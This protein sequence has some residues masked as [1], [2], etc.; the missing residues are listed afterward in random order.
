MVYVSSNYSHSLVYQ[1]SNV[2]PQ[3]GAC[4]RTD[5]YV[6]ARSRDMSQSALDDVM[7]HVG[8][9]CLQPTDFRLVSHEGLISVVS[10]AGINTLAVLCWGRGAQAPKSC[11]APRFSIGSIV[12]SLSHCC[13]PND[14]G[15]AHK[16]FFL[17]PPLNK[18]KRSCR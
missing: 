4:G 8:D 13:L 18:Q 11:P 9:L 14:E 3:T 1:C 5:V 6:M 10:L 15:Q 16:Y 7:K 2:N 17:E 12:I